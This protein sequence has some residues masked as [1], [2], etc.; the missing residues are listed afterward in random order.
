MQAFTQPPQALHRHTHYRHT[1]KSLGPEGMT[2]KRIGPPPR[3][4]AALAASSSLTFRP[5]FS[6]S[7]SSTDHPTNT[8]VQTCKK[9]NACL[10]RQHN[11]DNSYHL[12]LAEAPF[13]CSDHAQNLPLP[14]SRSS[15]TPH[16]NPSCIHT[17]QPRLHT[18]LALFAASF[19]ARK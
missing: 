7:F 3:L 2:T 11:H 15:P 6:I 17:T 19:P 18:P 8:R 12:M 13:Y 1:Y 10:L 4:A 14:R 16:T 5:G 9:R